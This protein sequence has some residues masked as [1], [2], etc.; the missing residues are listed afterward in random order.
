M[1]TEDGGT[2][3]TDNWQSILHLDLWCK[4]VKVRDLFC[5]EIKSV[6]ICCYRQITVVQPWFGYLL[7]GCWTWHPKMPWGER[8]IKTL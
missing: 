1:T 5:F 7:L 2:D 8:R 4:N 6:L 3:M